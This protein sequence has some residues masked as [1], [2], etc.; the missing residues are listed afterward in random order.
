[1]FNLET[2]KGN[3]DDDEV[4]SYKYEDN[5]IS[6]TYNLSCCLSYYYSNSNS[7]NYHN[8]VYFYYRNK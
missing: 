4:Q 7:C 8:V 2:T 1:M 5:V 6:D 3:K